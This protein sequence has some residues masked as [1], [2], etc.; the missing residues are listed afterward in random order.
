MNLINTNNGTDTVEE[1]PAPSFESLL[2]EYGQPAETKEKQTETNESELE[3]LTM[4]QDLRGKVILHIS[5]QE[6]EQDKKDQT[7]H[8]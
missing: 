1:K 6:K 7:E 5:N 8:V 2:S 3:K 4:I